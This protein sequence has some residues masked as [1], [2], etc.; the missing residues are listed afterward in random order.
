MKPI[1]FNPSAIGPASLA[2]AGL[3]REQ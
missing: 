3:R 2:Y 1:L